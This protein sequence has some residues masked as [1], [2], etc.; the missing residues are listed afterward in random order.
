MTF[1]VVPLMATDQKCMNLGI[2]LDL[3][4]GQKFS[5]RKKGEN[6]AEGEQQ[7]EAQ[8][9]DNDSGDDE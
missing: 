3:Y 5:R 6:E 8:T 1:F 2:G 4:A 7:D 9:D